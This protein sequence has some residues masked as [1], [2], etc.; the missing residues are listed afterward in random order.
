[1]SSALCSPNAAAVGSC[2]LEKGGN[3]LQQQSLFSFYVHSSMV[4]F[5]DFLPSDVF[6][7]TLIKDLT[8]AVWGDTS[9]AVRNLMLAALQV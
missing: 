5:T 9:D 1:M 4:N 2:A 8:K 6:H 3:S 7:G